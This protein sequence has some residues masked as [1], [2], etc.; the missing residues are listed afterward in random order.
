MR[1]ILTLPDGRGWPDLILQ[2]RTAEALAKDHPESRDD[3]LL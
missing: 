2:L 3:H 1:I